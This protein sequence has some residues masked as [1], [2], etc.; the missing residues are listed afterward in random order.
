MSSYPIGRA[1]GFILA[2]TTGLLIVGFIF[3]GTIGI[4]TNR[5]SAGDSDAIDGASITRANSMSTTLV[6][7]RSFD[8]L[9]GQIRAADAKMGQAAF[10]LR[11]YGGDRQW[12]GNY[13]EL[14][15]QCEGLVRK[16]NSA[17]ARYSVKAFEVAD[18]P[19]RIDHSDIT[20][21]CEENPR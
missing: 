2:W 9:L 13:I 1:I 3:Y 8:A 21:D 10:Y 6:G 19:S 4:F 14:L 12:T 16:Y 5:P 7:Q 15:H 18:L 17:A 20:T 11:T